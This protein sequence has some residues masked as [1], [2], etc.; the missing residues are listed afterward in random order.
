MEEARKQTD[1]KYW[2]FISYSHQDK[3]WGDW[4]HKA[5]E[6]YRIPSKLVGRESRDG[7]V[8]KRIFPIF[9]DREELPTSSDL[10]TVINDALLNSRYLIVICSPKS[11]KSQWVDAEIRYFKSLGCENRILCLIVDGEPNATDKPEIGQ[12]EC[13]PESVKYRVDAE[14]KLSS[15]RTE[16]IAADARDGKD[17]KLNSKLKLIAGLTGLNYDDLKQRDR[18]RRQ[19]NA[20]IAITAAS[21]IFCIV[22][23]LGVFSYYQWRETA[24]ERN[25]QNELLWQA[26][27]DDHAAAERE[28]HEGRWQNGLIYLFR[29]LRSQPF[30]IASAQLL[31]NSITTPK[32]N[33]PV[34]RWVENFRSAVQRV[35]F[36][37]DKRF[38]AVGDE[39]TI[40]L[41]QV[42]NG[43]QVWQTKPNSSNKGYED[44]AFSPDGKFI[45]AKSDKAVY[46]YSSATGA[47]IWMKADLSRSLSFSLDGK[48]FAAVS[49]DNVVRFFALETGQLIWEIK[50]GNLPEKKFMP[51]GKSLAVNTGGTGLTVDTAT[52]NEISRLTMS[53]GENVYPQGTFDYFGYSL[54]YSPDGRCIAVKKKYTIL[55]LFDAVTGEKIWEYKNRE[56]VG[57]VKFS[58]DGRCITLKGSKTCSFVDTASGQEI[59][60]LTN[61]DSILSVF[62]ATAYSPDGRYF[63][64]G[65]SEGITQLY[66]MPGIMKIWE[67]KSGSSI[68]DIYFSP[69]G[70]FLAIA[71]V[72]SVRLVELAARRESI[73][74]KNDS[75]K[76]E[77]IAFNPDGRLFAIADE[78]SISVVETASG[79]KHWEAQL[80]HVA[81]TAI[82][83]SPDSMMLAIVSRDS[84]AL[85]GDHTV[86]LF[87][88]QTGRV[89]WRLVD[90]NQIKSISFSPD[91][92]LLAIG[93]DDRGSVWLADITTG[94]RICK[95]EAGA[96]S[97]Q[98]T[99]IKSDEASKRIEENRGLAVSVN[100]IAFSPDSRFIA[101][102]FTTVRLV[103]IATGKEKWGTQQPFTAVEMLAFSPDGKFV[104]AGSDTNSVLLFEAETGREVL[105]YE[106]QL[107]LN[108]VAFNADGR[109]LTSAG[110]TIQSVEV[111]SGREVYKYT[112]SEF[113]HCSVGNN[114]NFFWQVNDNIIKLIKP[115]WVHEY[116]PEWLFKL[117]ATM[118]SG[119]SNDERG[120]FRSL[121]AQEQADI[122]REL[123]VVAA[124]ISKKTVAKRTDY[125]RLLLWLM[126]EPERRTVHP[127]SDVL[128]RDAVARDFESGSRLLVEEAHAEA[129]WHPL[130]P[131]ALA[132]F[133]EN[134]QTTA[135]LRN[136]TVKRLTAFMTEEVYDRDTRIRYWQQAAGML[137]QQGDNE[138]AQTAE[139]TAER[140]G[141]N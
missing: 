102:G 112:C 3:K 74:I 140:L 39:A 11:A 64:T 141:K 7:V 89:L 109:F 92:R 41:L 50:T 135:F 52:G 101:I 43:K 106:H 80:Q 127:D 94:H 126:T 22:T 32:S 122:Y 57:C 88:V 24:K 69:D 45:A 34:T 49:Q 27:R 73:K 19:R 111:P 44:I 115:F 82:A 59:F 67:F 15:E 114:S 99:I 13:F 138:T 97:I 33:M 62:N 26:S 30:N 107:S 37:P 91:S 124:A 136:L 46:L 6:T 137:R 120:G 104:A 70:E 38:L 81:I 123:S 129:P 16:P 110:N 75:N 128:L 134:K 79:K 14:G 133:E 87:E 90:G 4:L 77:G 2:A 17:G 5:L 78:D 121:L 35:A 119:L 47:E 71:D 63:V 131:L 132:Q 86:Q 116:P 61:T 98:K 72:F 40:I 130:A 84:K 100:S 83:F 12:E 117:W 54:D 10:G 76:T 113:D 53:N 139:A 36:S 56:G 1:Y 95:F 118:Q 21:L 9:R 125:E 58:P 51:D 60:N 68:R 8:P 105:K 55:S 108:S 93:S 29:S 23:G 103:E 66:S 18:K 42:T 28:F 20:A 48:F 65:T 25:K 96:G 85:T 31:V